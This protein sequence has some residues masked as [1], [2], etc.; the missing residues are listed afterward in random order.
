LT[1]GF[2]RNEE[3]IVFA[4]TLEILLSLQPLITT[5]AQYIDYCDEKYDDH[6]GDEGSNQTNHYID[7]SANVSRGG[8]QSRCVVIP[9]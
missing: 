5:E 4:A 9:T 1:A 7:F 8:A 2:A 6:D 3:K